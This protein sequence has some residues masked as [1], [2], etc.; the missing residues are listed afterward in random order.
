MYNFGFRGR[1]ASNAVGFQ[2]FGKHCSYQ[3]QGESVL[4]IL[5][6]LT[7]PDHVTAIILLLMTWS[8][9]TFFITSPKHV[10]AKNFLSPL[11]LTT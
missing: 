2:R 4:M 11:L 5:G 3:L 10:V 6:S 1:D 7:L 8:T 9:K